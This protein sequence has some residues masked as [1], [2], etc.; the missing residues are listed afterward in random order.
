MRKKPLLNHAY[1]T[2]D[3]YFDNATIEVFH[4][5]LKIDFIYNKM[6]ITIIHEGKIRGCQRG[7]SGL[8][9]EDRVFKDI[10][11]ATIKAIEDNRFGGVLT[12]NEYKDVDLVF[13]FFYDKQEFES[14]DINYLEK[15]IELGIHALQSILERQKF[16]MELIMTVMV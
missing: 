11:E 12:E 13:T 14:N 8:K 9:E 3:N 16:V 7:T 1:N 4:D 5:N 6:F 10:Q 2:L 15:Q